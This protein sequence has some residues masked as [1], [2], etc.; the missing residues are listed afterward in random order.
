MQ[1][2]GPGFIHKRHLQDKSGDGTGEGQGKGFIK[3]IKK[4]RMQMHEHAC[5]D[6][7]MG[8]VGSGHWPGR[9][10]GGWLLW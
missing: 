2:P 8:P 4:K 6:M 3:N 9:Q 10:A 7:A 1:W 5:A